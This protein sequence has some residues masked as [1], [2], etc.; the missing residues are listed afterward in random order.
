MSLLKNKMGSDFEE[1]IDHLVEEK[2]KLKLL[3]QRNEIMRDVKSLIKVQPTI[4]AR[5]KTPERA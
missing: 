2:I 3:N 5:P 4:V 1:R